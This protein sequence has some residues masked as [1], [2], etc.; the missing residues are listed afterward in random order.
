MPEISKDKLRAELRD[1]KLAPV[2]V[3]HGTE[4]Y[5]RDIAAKTICNLAFEDGGLRDF[6]ETEFSLNT[7]ENIRSAI[8]A[9]NQLPM[10]AARRVVKITDVRISSTAVRDTLKEGSEALL[11]SYLANPSTNS[12]VIFVA[13]ELNGNRKLSRLLKEHGRVIEFKPLDDAELA[14]RAREKI[15]DASCSIDEPA[16][17]HLVAIAG[18][19]LHRIEN[20]IKKLTT[21]ALPGKAVTLEMI[22]DL[23]P[24]S[25]EIE[26]FALTDHL[27]AG[28]TDKAF[29]AMK[30]ILDDG[31]EPLALLGLIS[32][33]FRR[34]LMAK[35][36]MA[37]GSDRVEVAKTVKLRY[38][39]QEQF[40]AA[41][42]RADPLLIKR[43]ITRLAETDL[44]IKTSAGGGGPFGSRMQL[45]V[46]VCE[47]S[48][49]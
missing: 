1:R 15:K 37:K 12:I 19:D 30:R 21:A 11:S 31:A 32:Y 17:R 24:Q 27:V 22:D 8:A 39:D 42:R 9:A 3:L 46:L 29:A 33:N 6:N 49:I 45:E 10:M 7:P 40:L 23:V 4:T 20:E 5:L 44:A 43:A 41:A 13:D 14:D 38:S 34:L 16:L 35:E 28:R 36:M 48:T 18:P 26:N 47:L 25:R 2:Y